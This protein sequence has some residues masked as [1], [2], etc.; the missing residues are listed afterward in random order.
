[1]ETK[2]LKE[3]I[4]KVVLEKLSLVDQSADEDEMEGHEVLR[5]MQSELDVKLYALARKLKRSLK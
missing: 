3:E 1:M 5:E 4:L 2:K